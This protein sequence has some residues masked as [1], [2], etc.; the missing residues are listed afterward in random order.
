LIVPL[1]AGQPYRF[2][3]LRAPDLASQDHAPCFLDGRLVE[4]AASTDQNVVLNRSAAGSLTVVDE[5]V[6]LPSSAGSRLYELQTVVCGGREL[7]VAS[8]GRTTRRT[9]VA[10]ATLEQV[11]LLPPFPALRIQ[12]MSTLLDAAGLI[13]VT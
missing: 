2:E 13:F 5:R 1:T 4:V 9:W 8:W 11:D 3:P 12:T 6:E 7:V 10:D